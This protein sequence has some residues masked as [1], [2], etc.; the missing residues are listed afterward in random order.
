M[1][2][3]IDFDSTAYPDGLDVPAQTLPFDTWKTGL[4]T[5][6]ETGNT[7]SYVSQKAKRK[8]CKRRKLYDIPI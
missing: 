3:N 8:C 4:E 5:D 1:L 6:S 2:L 7:K